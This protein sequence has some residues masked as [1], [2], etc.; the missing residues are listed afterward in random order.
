VQSIAHDVR[1]SIQ[2]E[3]YDMLAER[4]SVWLG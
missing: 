1:A 2:E 4:Q 3:L